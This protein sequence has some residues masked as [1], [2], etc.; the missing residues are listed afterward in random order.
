M[1]LL[2]LYRMFKAAYCLILD[3]LA[4][5]WARVSGLPRDV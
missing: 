5:L 1:N 2:R 4:L 3:H